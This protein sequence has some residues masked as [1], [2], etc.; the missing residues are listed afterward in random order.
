M[1]PYF[2]LISEIRELL[3]PFCDLAEESKAG[4]VEQVKT[5]QE[6]C[7]FVVVSK[8]SEPVTIICLQ[9]HLNYSLLNDLSQVLIL[10]KTVLF[11]RL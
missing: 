1:A 9:K 6:I 10:I 4:F 8:I 11:L 3:F 5:T 7:V 2:T